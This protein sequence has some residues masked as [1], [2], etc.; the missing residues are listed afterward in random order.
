MEE[1]KQKETEHYDRLAKEWKEKHAVEDSLKED[2]EEIDIHSFGSYRFLYSILKKY[3]SGKRVLDYGCGHGIHA[4]PIAEM[5]ASEVVGIDLSE[6]SLEIARDLAKKKNLSQKTNF[7]KMDAE[8]LEFKDETFDI[9]FDGGAFSS[10]DVK[11]VFPELKRVL[12]TDGYVIGIETLGHHPI[13]NLKRALNKKYGVRTDW[14]TSH[15]MKMDDFKLA[16]TYFSDV[17][18]YY[19]N[20]IS[21][22]A[23]PFRHFPGG[24]IFVGVFDFIDKIL[25][26]VP[27]FRH[28]AF[29][30][31][32]VL[33]K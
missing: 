29:K 23:L 22:L 7:I 32:F 26:L 13:A 12:K 8:N 21:F 25:F 15:I 1:Y 14:A 28:F 24:K 30:T 10:L 31:V 4:I 19:F 18:V 20:F 9:V 27:Y 33:K 11:N 6:E 16:K 17:K 3:V 2:I 5:G